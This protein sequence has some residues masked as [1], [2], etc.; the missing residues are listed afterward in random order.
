MQK[1]PHIF[2]FLTSLLLLTNCE[3]ETAEPPLVIAADDTLQIITVDNVT[4]YSAVIRGYF[5]DNADSSSITGLRLSLQNTKYI[6]TTGDY[7]RANYIGNGKSELLLENLYADTTY[8]LSTNVERNGLIYNSQTYKFRTHRLAAQTDSATDIYAFG[9]Q[10][11]MRLSEPID[12]KKFKGSYGIYYSTRERVIR[13]QSTLCD[14][15]LMVRNLTPDQTYYFRAFVLQR[16]ASHRDVYIWGDALSFHTPKIG[17]TTAA[18][19]AVNTYSAKLSGDVN[20]LF[21]DAT[22]FGILFFEKNRDVTIDSV[23]AASD[24]MIQK[25]APDYVDERGMGVFSVTPKALKA[26]K[27]YCFRAF[28][29]IKEKVGNQTTTKTHYGEVKTFKTLPIVLTSGTEADLGLSVIWATKNFGAAYIYGFG[30]SLSL[31]DAAST[32]FPSGWR[33]PTVEEA[34]ELMEQCNWS[35]SRFNGVN[36]VEV[37]SQDG[38]AIFLPANMEVGGTYTYGV[39]ILSSEVSSRGYAKSML[40]LQDSYNDSQCGKSADNDV[41]SSAPIAVRLVR[42]R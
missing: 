41:L 29:T 30:Q 40:F 20:V 11:N 19:E 6:T 2:L 31:D 23:G 25:L 5:G 38:T 24:Q 10:L 15:S 17:V 22:D 37:V 7:F 4:P 26:D 16:T 14:S 21:S 42:D 33:L 9:A 27:R 36:G 13:E 32:T 1:L 18:P 3:K 12:P 34:Q 35:W 39:Y 8:Y 28:A